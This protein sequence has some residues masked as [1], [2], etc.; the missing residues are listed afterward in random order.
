MSGSSEGDGV[1][2]E[3]VHYKLTTWIVVEE[4]S[5]GACQLLNSGDTVIKLNSSMG[6]TVNRSPKLIPQ[7]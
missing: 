3:V 7:D 6:F 5:L 1:A 2:S 4:S